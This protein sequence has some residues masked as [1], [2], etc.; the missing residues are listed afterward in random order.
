MENIQHF[1]PNLMD[2]YFLVNLFSQRDNEAKNADDVLFDMFR[3]ETTDLLP[4]GKFLAVSV[5]VFSTSRF[6]FS[7][8][9][10][11]NFPLTSNKRLF[12]HRVFV[13]PINASGKWWTIYVKF[14]V[15]RIARVVHRKHRNWTA[16][17]SNRKYPK[18]NKMQCSFNIFTEKKTS[19]KN[20]SHN[21]TK[22]N[23]RPM[24]NVV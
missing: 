16:I 10:W 17:H 4:I 9:N 19:R 1:P 23:F 20:N 11:W 2:E 22:F 3:N 6:Y 5:N 8:I 14:I 18:P 12:A 21:K 13:W 15:C 24:W 7:S